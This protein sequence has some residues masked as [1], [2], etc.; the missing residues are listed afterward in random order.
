[1]IF[2]LP[3]FIIAAAIFSFSA[4]A[5]AASKPG[6]KP[7]AKSAVTRPA[8]N[9]P[10][11]EQLKQFDLARKIV[12]SLGFGEGLPEKPSENDYLQ[13]LAGA[14]T[15]RFEAEETF[16][17]QSDPVTVRNY[18]LYGAF[19]GTG[20]IHGT[21]AQTAVHFKVFIPFSGK[22]TMKVVAKGDN[23]LWSVAGR[24][25]KLNSGEKLKESTLGQVFIPA[26]ELEFNAVIPPAGAIDSVLFTAPSYTPIEPHGGWAPAKPLSAAAVNEVTASLLGLE[27]LLPDDTSYGKKVIEAA[28]LSNLPATVQIT[29]IQFLGKP[30]AAKWV[31]AFQTV[32]A[33]AVPIEIEVASVYRIRVRAVGTEISAGFGLRRVSTAMKPDLEWIDLGTFRL[34][35]GMNILE[36]Q[37]PPL[38]GIDIIEV[39]KKLSSPADYAAATKS[40]MSG[41]SPIKPEDLE[42]IIK[43]LQGQFKERR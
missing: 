13:I 27:P 1:M 36:L 26:G 23:Q 6:V 14:R 5:S 17:R 38:G 2:R 32:A 31:R 37:L 29:N 4:S 41:D 9:K 18:P 33:L 28:S 24:A 15:F 3:F 22:Y 21:T 30:V 25:F 7:A 10:A 42:T 16:D 39:T 11:P 40:G 12:D 34:P 35:K 8:E 43:L 19:S 20:W